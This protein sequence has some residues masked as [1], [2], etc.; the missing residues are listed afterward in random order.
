MER[1]ELPDVSV[2]ERREID[3]GTEPVDAMLELL[4]AAGVDVQRR[5]PAVASQVNPDAIDHLYRATSGRWRMEVL[6]WN[7]PVVF[8]PD[9]IRVHDADDDGI[10]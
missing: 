4:E 5:E 7:H 6:I 1:I 8:T 9:E 3:V 2:V 10:E